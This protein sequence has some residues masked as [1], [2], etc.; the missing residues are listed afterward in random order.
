[1]V[2]KIK[3]QITKAITQNPLVYISL[4]L[5]SSL[6]FTVSWH[7]ITQ[8][9]LEAVIDRMLKTNSLKGRFPHTRTLGLRGDAVSRSKDQETAPE[10]IGSLW[11]APL[12]CSPVDFGLCACWSPWGKARGIANEGYAKDTRSSSA[13]NQLKAH[14]RERD[15]PRRQNLSAHRPTPLLRAKEAP[16]VRNSVEEVTAAAGCLVNCSC[17]LQNH[18][19]QPHSPILCY[20]LHCS[21]SLIRHR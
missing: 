6:I 13:A 10:Q 19:V 20:H 15:L 11:L 9:D 17:T 1:M 18:L 16:L 5:P 2:L 12:D 3:K 7:L 4:R 14:G 8:P 21:D